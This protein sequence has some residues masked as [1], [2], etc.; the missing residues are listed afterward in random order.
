MH[1]A[2]RNI[3]HKAA[4][5]DAVES[6]HQGAPSLGVEAAHPLEV[7]GECPLRDEIGDDH[8]I[9]QRGHRRKEI[10]IARKAIDLRR[11]HD[12]I[13]QA[14]SRAEN[15]AERAG[16][17]DDVRLIQALQRRK[18]VAFVAEFAVVIIFQDPRAG[19]PPPTPAARAGE[20][21]RVS[22][23]RDIGSMA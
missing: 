3:E 7:P 9:E 23:P 8:L 22:P 2:A 11:G 14:Q 17:E 6:G 19:P 1:S 15:L 10:G 21:A 18:R 20:E 12:E 4:A 5:E 16:I 13:P